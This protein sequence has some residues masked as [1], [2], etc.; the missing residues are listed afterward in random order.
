MLRD[1]ERAV[2]VQRIEPVRKQEDIEAHDDVPDGVTKAMEHGPV[3]EIELY[4]RGDVAVCIL[5]AEQRDP[6]DV[7]RSWLAHVLVCKDEDELA[8]YE[9]RI[10]PLP[11]GEESNMDDHLSNAR[12]AREKGSMLIGTPE[13]VAGQFDEIQELGFE[14][15]QLMFL[16]F[17][18]T[19][20][21]ELFGDNVIPQFV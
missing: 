3:T 18:E 15:L 8:E 12:E 1:T 10:F 9:D 19:R 21:M 4:V 2:N 16:G 7:E 13:Q 11:W 5:E 20:G 6:D 17:P 14:K